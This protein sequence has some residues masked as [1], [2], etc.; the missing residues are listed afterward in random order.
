MFC[1]KTFNITLSASLLSCFK[2]MDHHSSKI[3]FRIWT[4]EIFKFW[5]VIL[6]TLKATVL[7]F[8]YNRQTKAFSDCFIIYSL[9]I[10]LREQ[11]GPNHACTMHKREL[12]IMG[13]D[14]S[15][16]NVSCSRTSH[17]FALRNSWVAVAVY[18]GLFSICTVKCCLISFTALAQYTS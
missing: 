17:I 16:L 6:K 9:R 3:C 18:F 1:Q 15:F 14:F 10:T 2:G 12:S 4:S 5:V 13:S 7:V 8:F 11:M